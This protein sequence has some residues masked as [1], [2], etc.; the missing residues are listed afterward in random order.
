[1]REPVTA[2]NHHGGEHEED[3]NQDCEEDD[4]LTLLVLPGGNVVHFSPPH[5]HSRSDAM[6]G[7]VAS[8]SRRMVVRADRVIVPTL[9]SG[10]SSK[11]ASRYTVIASPTTA[12]GTQCGPAAPGLEAH[13]GPRLVAVRE[14]LALEVVREASVCT[15]TP[16][17]N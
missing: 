3:G 9:K 14:R 7:L 15:T 6:P 8:C 16:Q 2:R 1:M 17:H 10:T 11:G 12:L 4:D 13:V 5:G